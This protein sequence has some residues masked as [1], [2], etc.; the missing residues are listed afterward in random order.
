MMK[1]T[2]SAKPATNLAIKR[3]SIFKPEDERTITIA[4][5]GSLAPQRGEGLRV[6]GEIAP[7]VENRIPLLRFMECAQKTKFPFSIEVR[8]RQQKGRTKVRP[9]F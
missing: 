8:H 3:D 7:I 2:N 1:R 4:Q 6:R 5:R 9:H